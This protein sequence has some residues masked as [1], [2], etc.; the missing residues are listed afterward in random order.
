MPVKVGDRFERLLV[1]EL[2][3]DRKNPKAKCICDCG[4]TVAPQRGSLIN[5]RAKSCGCL[6][7]DKFIA[8]NTSHG[9]SGSHMYGIWRGMRARCEN[10]RDKFFHNYGGRGIRVSPSWASFENFARDMGPCP[11]GMTLERVNTN[12]DY[13]K[14]NCVWADWTAQSTNK[15]VSRRWTINGVEYRSSTEAA[16][17]LGVDKSTIN[18]RANGYAKRGRIYAP[19]KGY[20]S[21]LVYSDSAKGLLTDNAKE[22]A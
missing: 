1:I 19:V 20:C 18:R 14:E 15:R 12:G 7:A 3:R 11:L 10:P 2:I 8:R 9:Q 16:A 4:K 21:S 13:E 5:G 6:R 17:A 22:A